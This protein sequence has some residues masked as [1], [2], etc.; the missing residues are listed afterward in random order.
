[1][2]IYTEK[3]IAETGEITGITYQT[4]RGRHAESIIMTAEPATGGK[5]GRHYFSRNAAMY[6]AWMQVL[7]YGMPDDAKTPDI[8]KEL[9]SVTRT[10]LSLAKMPTPRLVTTYIDGMTPAACAETIKTTLKALESALTERPALAFLYPLYFTVLRSIHLYGKKKLKAEA[11]TEAVLPALKHI[12]RFLSSFEIVYQEAR[13]YCEAV[14]LTAN[15]PTDGF[16]P[17]D[18]AS[19]YHSY[20]IDHDLADFYTDSMQAMTMQP[21][22]LQ[23]KDV[24][25]WNDY[26]DTFLTDT[27]DE[28]K[29][30]YP[31]TSFEQFLHIGIDRMLEAES[32]MRECKLCGGFYRIRFSSTQEYCTRLYGKTKATCNEYASRKSYKDRL[33]KHPIHTEF[34]KSYNRLYGRIRRGKLPEDTPLMNELKALHDAYYVKYENTHRQDREAVWREYMAKNKELLG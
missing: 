16:L 32:V 18:M 28:K 1:M 25:L 3:F 10:Q 24:T 17:A 13:S 9:E 2:N 15:A 5:A 6:S 23:K 29:K 34:T 21:S 22:L 4:D 12:D 26:L 20:C 14:F 30:I 33:F 7:D 31:L 19:V 27:G 11:Y 8:I